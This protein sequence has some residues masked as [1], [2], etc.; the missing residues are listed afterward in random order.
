M[1]E[2]PS[3]RVVWH[4][5]AV[6][7]RSNWLQFTA[8]H[9]KSK[10]GSFLELS[11]AIPFYCLHKK[12]LLRYCPRC[13][14]ISKPSEEAITLE[15][16]HIC[17]CENSVAQKQTNNSQ[18]HSNKK[19]AAQIIQACPHQLPTSLHTTNAQWRD[20]LCCAVCMHGSH[21]AL[22]K[23]GTI[24]NIQGEKPLYILWIVILQKK[25]P[26][27]RFHFIMLCFLDVKNPTGYKMMACSIFEIS[28]PLW[29]SW[30]NS[31]EALQAQPWLRQ[32]CQRS[33][34][35]HAPL[36]KNSRAQLLTQKPRLCATLR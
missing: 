27:W 26:P 13:S 7:S 6:G 16:P 33:K 3:P 2:A 9:S 35:R 18:D 23:Y 29:T 1:E 31:K 20:K 10:P 25:K 30:Y 11:N 34:Q 17:M 4:L 28:W 5:R 22:S 21:L 19:S 12:C 24:Q 15:V 36:L 32:L 8:C 14:A